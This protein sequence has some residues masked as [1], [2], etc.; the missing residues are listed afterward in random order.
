MVGKRLKNNC[1][2]DIIIDDIIIPAK[3]S[4]TISLTKFIELSNNS[5]ALSNSIKN[6]SV[7]IFNTN[8]DNKKTMLSNDTTTNNNTTT[9]NVELQTSES[10]A[11]EEM[12]ETVDKTPTKSVKRTRKRKNTKK[13]K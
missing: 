8:V 9:N 13:N 10:A 2:S 6:K 3:S 1:S 12:N 5:K 7:V 4:V 11:N